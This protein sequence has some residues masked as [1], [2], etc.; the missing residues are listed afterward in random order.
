MVEFICPESEQ[1]EPQIAYEA[2]VNFMES[3]IALIR[4][5][6]ADECVWF[7]SHPPLYTRGTGACDTDLLCAR[8]PVYSSGRG[9]AFTYHGPGQRVIYLMLDL[10]ARQIMVRDYV[11]RL[12]QWISAVL[13]DFDVDAYP[14]PHAVGVWVETPERAKIAAIGIR[15]RHWISFHGVSLNIAPDLRHYDGIVPCGIR[16]YPMTSLAQLG[17][18]VSMSAIDA[19]LI[20]HFDAF[21]S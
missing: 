4:R 19:A 5:E 10:Q 15:V 6:A 3:R 2:A 17:R 8:L 12:A 18:T 9:G 21:F 16:E 7:L 20:K 13:A 1:S 11:V 14:D